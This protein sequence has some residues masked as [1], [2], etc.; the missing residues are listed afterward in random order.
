[1]HESASNGVVGDVSSRDDGGSS[2]SSRVGVTVADHLRNL[3]DWLDA[4]PAAEV[5][6]VSFMDVLFGD[7]VKV[8]SFGSRSLAKAMEQSRR[9]GG[10]W[11]RDDSETMF[12]LKQ[13]IMPGFEFV[14]VASK[15]PEDVAA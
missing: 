7:P 6:Q 3:A 14:I 13:A 4:H 8:W 9:I 2:P 10:E 11:R 1:M 5:S 12:Y 15:P